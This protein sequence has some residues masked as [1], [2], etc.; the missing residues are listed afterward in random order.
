V[1]IL[2]TT[3]ETG[4]GGREFTLAF[5]G[6]RKF[7]GRKNTLKF[8]TK[9]AETEDA[10]RKE[11]A[12][13]YKIGLMP[14]VSQ[15]NAVE[16]I[17]VTYRK[18]EEKEKSK[19]V[20]DPWDHWTF[21][22]SVQGYINGEKTYKY[23]YYYSSFSVNRVTDAWKFNVYFSMSHTRT[24]YDYGEALKYT[25]VQRSNYASGAVIKSLTPHWSLGLRASGSK[26]TYNNYDL[27]ASFAP[28]IEYNVFPYSES[29]RKQF[30]FQ[31]LVTASRYDY[32]EETIYLKTIENRFSEQLNVAYEVK[33]PWGTIRT[34]LYSSHFIDDMKKYN[35]Q[36]D[37]SIDLRLFKGFSLNCYGY[38][39]FLRDQISLP[40][41]G[42]S[43]EEILL[44]RRQLQ[45]SYY[46][47]M[48]VGLSYTFGSIYNN[49]VNPRFGGL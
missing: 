47:Y 5:I 22:T 7:E 49:I 39:T 26:S 4:G 41:R 35:V 34:S 45:T 10:I 18:P 36:W 37:N 3:Q 38:M 31:Y 8:T 25:D 6:L 17:D 32:H 2:T 23:N 44:R 29:T 27:A 15:S 21:R 14:F 48:S 46:Y 24:D 11:L 42:A 13:Y 43:I 9:P 1:H 16:R 20:K 12:R 30:T 33:Q 28:G 19:A 40:R